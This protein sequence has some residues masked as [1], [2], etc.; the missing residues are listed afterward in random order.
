[1]GRKV[2]NGSKKVLFMK[3]WMKWMMWDSSIENS[4]HDVLNPFIFFTH[5]HLPLPPPTTLAPLHGDQGL[6]S[7]VSPLLARPRKRQSW[8]SDRER[9]EAIHT[10]E[11]WTKDNPSKGRSGSSFLCM[12]WRGEVQSWQDTCSWR[13]QNH[14]RGGN[15]EREGAEDSN[16]ESEWKSGSKAWHT[17]HGKGADR[18]CV[19]FTKHCS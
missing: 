13:M 14:F 7:K 10:V 11:G 1:M 18:D 3:K 4:N 8:I 17:L 15:L 16:A 9:D 19:N 12:G 5:T 6:L 2:G